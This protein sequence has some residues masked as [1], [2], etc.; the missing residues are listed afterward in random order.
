MRQ[1]DIYVH[2]Y[3]CIYVR[4]MYTLYTCTSMCTVCMCDRCCEMPAEV[5]CLDIS[6]EDS[7]ERSN[8]CAVGLWD[9]SARILSVP[10]LETLR[11]EELG[12]GESAYCS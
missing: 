1:S 2:M 8:I 6:C 12:G 3:I 5:A 4:D 10:D 7:V 11:V 9:I